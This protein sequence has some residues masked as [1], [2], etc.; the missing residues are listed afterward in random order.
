MALQNTRTQWEEERRLV[1]KLQ[2]RRSKH[3]TRMG[4]AQDEM[5]K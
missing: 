5:R 1:R 4:S 3:R 2:A